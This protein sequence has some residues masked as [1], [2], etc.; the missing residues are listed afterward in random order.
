[1]CRGLLGSVESTVVQLGGPK[2]NGKYLQKLIR[3][4][5][6]QTR[7]HQTLTNVVIPT[8][9]IKNMQ[10]TIFSSY[11]VSLS[12]LFVGLTGCMGKGKLIGH[13]Q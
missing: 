11:E 7:L 12:L 8:F 2:Y 10:P 1:M 9:D 4:N 13:R 6:G 3:D 5:L